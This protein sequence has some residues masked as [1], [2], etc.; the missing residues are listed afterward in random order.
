MKELQK[1]I[2]EVTRALTRMEVLLERERESITGLPEVHAILKFSKIY[3]NS[4]GF[5]VL[6]LL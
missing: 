6:C 2:K 3:L 5:Y 4:Y 1:F